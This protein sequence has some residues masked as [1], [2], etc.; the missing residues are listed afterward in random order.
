[1]KRRCKIISGLWVI[2]LKA[3]GENHPDVAASY[4]NIGNSFQSLGRREE[5]LQ[6]H[7]LALG[8]W[9]KAFG[10]NHP[11]VADS[12]N[13]IGI[14][15]QSLGRHEEA[16]HSY[17]QALFATWRSQQKESNPKILKKRLDNI[18]NC[19]KRDPKLW[20]TPAATE[21]VTFVREQLGEKSMP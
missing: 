10:E 3:F 20:K 9:L 7:Q 15:L 11:D 6:N 18:L 12:Y 8:I 19:L 17:K 14:S 5:A 16:L 1:M 2:W 4:N 13:N 21:I